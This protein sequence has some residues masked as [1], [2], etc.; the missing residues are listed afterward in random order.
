MYVLVPAANGTS[1]SF[2]SV[3]DSTGTI[4]KAVQISDFLTQL[5]IGG[6]GALYATGESKPLYKITLAS[7]SVS[8]VTLELNSISNVSDY[9]AVDP[10]GSIYAFGGSANPNPQASPNS[11]TEF[12]KLSP[13]AT[14]APSSLYIGIPSPNTGL[15]FEDQYLSIGPNHSFFVNAT[16]LIP[17]TQQ[18]EPHVQVYANVQ[19]PCGATPILDFT[20]P[21]PGGPGSYKAAVDSKGGVFL[22]DT[23]RL[24]VLPSRLVKRNG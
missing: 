5:F 4:G 20:V 22:L 3:F 9:Q 18:F 13:G 16:D 2:L 11:C 1:P 19:N 15:Q 8:D 7:G 10:D 14:Q 6:D 24:A 23:T 12:Y 21:P 17:L